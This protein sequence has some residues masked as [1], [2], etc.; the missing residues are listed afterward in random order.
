TLFAADEPVPDDVHEATGR[1]AFRIHGDSVRAPGTASKGC[2]IL[3][4]AVR[5]AIWRS[6]DRD[7]EVVE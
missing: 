5:E 6:G 3:P 7:L 4:R 1:S 2:I